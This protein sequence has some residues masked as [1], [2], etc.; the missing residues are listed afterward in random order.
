VGAAPTDR[1][2][3]CDL[4]RKRAPERSWPLAKGGRSFGRIRE[5]VERLTDSVGTPNLDQP[6]SITPS[7]PSRS[8][9]SAGLPRAALAVG[10]VR[11][12]RVGPRTVVLA[13]VRP[14]RSRSCSRP[15]PVRPRPRESPGSP[16][17]RTTGQLARSRSGTSDSPPGT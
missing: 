5:H 15:K 17:M 3:G 10:V 12:T 9:C 8:R 6:L 4:K 11:W 13:V 16:L 7:P 14:E 1:K 2:L